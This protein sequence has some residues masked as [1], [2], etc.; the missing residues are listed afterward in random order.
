VAQAISDQWQ[1]RLG[2]TIQPGEIGRQKVY[3]SYGRFY[4]EFSSA[5]PA[6]YYVDGIISRAIIYEHDP[7]IDPSGG[8]VLSWVTGIL[9]EI[10][11][12]GQYY[13]EVTVGYEHEVV[14][15][16]KGGVRG[17]YRALGQAVEDAIDPVTSTYV[18]GNPGRGLL[19]AFPAA[20]RD[21]RAL[22]ITI[23][24]VGGRRLNLMASYVL[25]RA[26]GN[27]TGLFGS[28]FNQTY[29]NYLSTFDFLETTENALGLMPNDRRHA[30]KL[31][32]SYG[33]G[34]GVTTGM[35][36]SWLS[37]TPLSEWG[38]SSVGYGVTKLI[39]TRGTAGRSP[40][41]WDLNLRLAYTPPGMARGSVRPRFLCDVFHLGNPR[42]PVDFDQVH[43]LALD[44][45][46]NQSQPNPTYGLP[47]RY[48]P[49]V[50]VRGGVELSF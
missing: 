38:G 2:I 29:P 49:P 17:V 1:P 28:D 10:D 23:A 40:A 6:T 7:R 33:V 9:P 21:Y 43:Y 44:E 19:S 14:P 47:T 22:E 13:D 27:Y 39:S 12:K 20:E 30:F 45:D 25:S 35:S 8:E 48:Q 15:G 41:I 32:G 3:A 4:Q 11:M 18:F 36:F 37:G 24:K 26:H 42:K 34:F 5:V 50:A 46:G 31:S 16:I